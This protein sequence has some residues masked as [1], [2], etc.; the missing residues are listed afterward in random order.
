VSENMKSSP[1]NL[2][3]RVIAQIGLAQQRAFKKHQASFAELDFFL[4]HD[5]P[6]LHASLLSAWQTVDTD[7]LEKQNKKELAGWVVQLRI[8]RSLWK[9]ALQAFDA[10]KRQTMQSAVY[11]AAA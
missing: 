3:A 8:W 1:E 11:A 6:Q 4:L 9:Q 10:Y 7:I 5:R 2:M